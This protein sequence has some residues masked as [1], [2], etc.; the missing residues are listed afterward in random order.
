[1]TWAKLDDGFHSHPKIRAALG[2][3]PAAIALHSLAIAFAADYETDGHVPAWFP[4]SVFPQERQRQS[5]LDVLIDL[6]LWTVNGDGHLI[7]DYLDYNP[8]KKSLDKR[9]AADAERKRQE[10][11]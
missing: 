8:S 11:S 5:A 6:G 7:H 9:R 2:R 3:D 1:M 10:R 4:E